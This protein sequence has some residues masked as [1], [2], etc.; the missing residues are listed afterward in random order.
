[1][2]QD[3][4]DQAADPNQK[5]DPKQREIMENRQLPADDVTALEDDIENM[6]NDPSKASQFL[7][8]KFEMYAVGDM[9]IDALVQLEQRHQGM[10]EIEA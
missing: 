1:M 5:I 3:V 2:A 4:S 8:Q 9:M 7:A 10:L 6:I